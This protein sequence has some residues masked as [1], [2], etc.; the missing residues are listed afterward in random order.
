MIDHCR[1]F[2]LTC[3]I[4]ANTMSLAAD[5]QEM[6][7]LQLLF[8]DAEQA[9]SLEVPKDIIGMLKTIDNM[10]KDFGGYKEQIKDSIPLSV[11]AALFHQIIDILSEAKSVLRLDKMRKNKIILKTYDINQTDQKELE[12]IV[13]E[14]VSWKAMSSNDLLCMLESANYLDISVIWYLP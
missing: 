3:L 11:G 12:N 7:K 14:I 1:L 9:Q 10:M 4:I 2:M 5:V 6:I 13:E 8:D